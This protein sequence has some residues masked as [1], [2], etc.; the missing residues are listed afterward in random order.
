MPSFSTKF[1]LVSVCVALFAASCAAVHIADVNVPQ[2]LVESSSLSTFLPPT[3]PAAP[4][5]LAVHVKHDIVLP[6]D[7]QQR[8]SSATVRLELD[9]SDSV[10]ALMYVVRVPP[11]VNYARFGLVQFDFPNY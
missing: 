10:N 1:K 7:A 9:N 4:R 8:V 11:G 6:M 2:P 5:P 3:G